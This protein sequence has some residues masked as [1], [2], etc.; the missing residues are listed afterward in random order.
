MPGTVLV[1]DVNERDISLGPHGP[2]IPAGKDR[3]RNNHNNS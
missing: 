2:S 3:H 1:T